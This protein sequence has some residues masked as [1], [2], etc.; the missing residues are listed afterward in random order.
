MAYKPN[1]FGYKDS[2]NS[3][4]PEKVIKGGDFDVEF[5]AIADAFEDVEQI[6][7]NTPG[8][9][10][11][12][13]EPDDEGFED[14]VFQNR[15]EDQQVISKFTF[16]YED[17]FIGNP[18]TVFEWAEVDAS[19]QS[20]KLWAGV[21]HNDNYQPW[22]FDIRGHMRAESPLTMSSSTTHMNFNS[23][24]MSQDRV[25]TGQL[26]DKY[27]WPAYVKYFEFEDKWSI[28][29]N[30]EIEGDLNVS[31]NIIIDGQIVNPDGETF[32]N[33]VKKEGEELQEI[34]GS[35]NIGRSL[36]VGW[37]AT[38][39]FI[40][41]DPQ[42]GIGLNR[43]NGSCLRFG[44]KKI[45]PLVLNE[46]GDTKEGDVDLGSSSLPFHDGYFSGSLTGEA[47][48]L[49]G[50]TTDQLEDVESATAKLDQFL[51]HN[52]SK[53]I[54]EDFHIDTALT[55]Q[56]AVDLTGTAPANPENGDLYINDTD[57][58]V[59]AS[60]GPIA[61]KSVITGN[62]VG[63]SSSKGRWY[64]LGDLNS[65]SVIQ[66][67][68]GD[69]IRVDESDPARPVVHVNQ[70]TQD[71][72]ALG[73]EAHSWGNHASDIATLESALNQE[74][75]NR[76]NGD[77]TL[78]AKI[79]KEI[80]DRTDGD[81]ALQEQ[82]NALSQLESGDVAN[83]QGQIN[84]EIQDRKDG[85]L[86]LQGQITQNKTDI[87]DLRNDFDSHDHKLNDLSDVSAGA[88]VPGCRDGV[89]GDNCFRQ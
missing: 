26:P 55:F 53:W 22:Q 13:I 3:G 64:L 11:G 77:N 2:L 17:E 41:I 10:G 5:E 37:E 56:G 52:G 69:C 14:V 51:I 24:G 66:V 27:D 32:E 67:R 75:V 63:Y 31:G 82:I 6:L 36:D 38:I 88:P 33:Y 12:T 42:G 80:T 47:S 30:L 70:D 1:N 59:D 61:G 49:T 79:D 83:L 62:V 58:I 74:I 39:G 60:W 57:G 78:D 20:L 19:N 73:V 15:S 21:H 25:D 81:L 48:Q 7:E 16:T 87:N 54:A 68:N 89:F 8:A 29:P 40:N 44:Q 65:A 86:A 18:A 85:D 46:D 76:E 43:L 35:I 72:I 28:K 9:G 71:D 50:I 34:E 45:T 84:Q 4:D 23:T